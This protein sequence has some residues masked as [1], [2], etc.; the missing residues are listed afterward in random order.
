MD[1]WEEE[2]RGDF[3]AQCTRAGPS[4]QSPFAQRLP[5]YCFL[6]LVAGELADVR[7]WGGTPFSQEC[8][9]G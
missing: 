9:G 3:A 1:V 8:G 6:E 7:G 2:F 5:R 4:E